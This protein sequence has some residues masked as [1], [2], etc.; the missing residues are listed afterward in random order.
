MSI[1]HICR[2]KDC[3]V[4]SREELA[5][6]TGFVLFLSH[7]FTHAGKKAC[8]QFPVFLLFCCRRRR[9]EVS[10]LMEYKDSSDLG[11]RNGEVVVVRMCLVLTGCSL[12]LSAYHRRRSAPPV[13]SCARTAPIPSAQKSVGVSSGK[14]RGGPKLSLLGR[15]QSSDL[16]NG[17]EQGVLTVALYIHGKGYLQEKY[18]AYEKRTYRGRIAYSLVLG[19]VSGPHHRNNG[20]GMGGA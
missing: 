16:R 3:V 14:R 8:I 10:Y 2:H 7:R 13:L 17:H 15:H 20:M 12:P 9:N 5:P 18:V 6:Y 19:G 1:L 11:T 4:R